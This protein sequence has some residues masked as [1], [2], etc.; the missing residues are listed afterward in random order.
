[1]TVVKEKNN[2]NNNNKK[3]VKRAGCRLQAARDNRG[4]WRECVHKVSSATS[5]WTIGTSHVFIQSGVGLEWG[6]KKLVCR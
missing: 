5:V 2:K 6:E 3:S 1:M 4:E